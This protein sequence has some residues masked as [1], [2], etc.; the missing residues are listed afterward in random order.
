MEKHNQNAIED[1]IKA[2][3]LMS[4]GL[5]SALAAQIIMD[6]GIEVFGLN[7]HS[8]F[9]T[10]SNA[11][12]K[13]KCA[14]IYFG[15]KVGIPVKVKGKGDKY[16]EIVRNPKYGYGKNMNPCIDCRIHILKEAAK[17]MEK[18]GAKFV[19]TGEVL[20]QRP[21]SQ[22][23]QAMQ[24]IEEQSGLA[25]KLL[26]PL[27]A[28]LLEPTQVEIKKLVNRSELL[29]I[30]GRRRNI[31][32]ELG[33][34]FELINEYCAGGGCKLTDKHFAK[35]LRDYFEHNSMVAMKDMKY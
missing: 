9:C 2:V 5:D 26:R 17:Y 6:Q 25:G 30:K 15:E 20:G 13:G 33:K 12:G 16:L 22:N 32:L 11:L 3:A 10:C 1:K 31:Q 27:S 24:I 14:A 29:E 21:K 19:I 4:G 18:V 28:K 34:N 7:F 35:K 8:P 23:L